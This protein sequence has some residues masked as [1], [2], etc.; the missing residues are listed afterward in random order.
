MFGPLGLRPYVVDWE[1]TAEALVRRVHREAVGGVLDEGTKRL[2]DE[3]LAEP[4][5]P[6][7][8]RRPSPEA[9][10]LPILPLTFRK[11][12]KAF[13]YF[14]MVTTLGTPQD[15]LLQEVRIETFFPFDEETRR[16]AEEMAAE[17]T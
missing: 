5:V 13:R 12:G 10:P 3:V 17:G 6:A 4:G 11:E 14:S 7:R 8:R 2:L 16:L 15:V 1:E 9:P